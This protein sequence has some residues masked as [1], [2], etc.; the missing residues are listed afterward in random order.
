MV[1]LEAGGLSPEHS[2]KIQFNLSGGGFLEGC[3]ESQD[4][5]G[6]R[7]VSR[8]PSRNSKEKL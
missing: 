7:G 6:R 8:M 2:G 3:R 4:R 1:A 5:E